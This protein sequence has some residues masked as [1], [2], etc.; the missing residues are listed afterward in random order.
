MLYLQCHIESSQFISKYLFSTSSVPGTI[1]ETIS[2]NTV[3]SALMESAFQQ[4]EDRYTISKHDSVLEGDK[5]FGQKEEKADEVSQADGR[6]CNVT[7]GFQQRKQLEQMLQG[8]SKPGMLK[9]QQGG[10][11]SG[12]NQR[13]GGGGKVGTRMGREMRRYS[14]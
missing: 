10:Q 8:W 7:L 11:W 1:L 6:S 2:A 13:E 9:E 12:V 4:R 5:C 14:F 3:I